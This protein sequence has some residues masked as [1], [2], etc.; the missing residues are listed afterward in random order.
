M[1]RGSWF[2]TAVLL[3]GAAT[4]AC[5]VAAQDASSSARMHLAP[6]DEAKDISGFADFVATFRRAVQD[7]DARALLSMTSE[8][9]S[10][11]QRS[12][13]RAAFA[14]EFGLE[15][16]A[17]FFWRR[18]SAALDGGFA[19][20]CRKEVC[21]VLAPWWP[22][23]ISYSGLSGQAEHAIAR[24][25]DVPLFSQATTGARVLTR[26]S[27]DLVE[28]LKPGSIDGLE[29]V[30][31]QAPDGQV[32]FVRAVDLYDL[33]FGSEFIFQRDANGRWFLADYNWGSP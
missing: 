24:R 25:A 5:G 17:S 6:R 30:H 19:A 16:G 8:R 9:V 2:R 12:R 31:V 27:F 14:K 20:D 33:T 4:T 18:A 13:G 32:G 15:D 26:L 23:R 22:H 7:K 21:L 1:T 3:L 10:F 28:K 29:F 11:G